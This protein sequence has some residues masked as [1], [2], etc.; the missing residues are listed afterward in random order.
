MNKHIIV[1][2][3]TPEQTARIA[4]TG[5][6]VFEVIKA[7]HEMDDDWDDL[8]EA[9]NWLSEEQLR[10]AL[11]YYAAHKA[12]LDERLASDERVEE[13]VQEVWRQ[14]PHMKPAWR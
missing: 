11:D 13:R 14:Y 3:W 8:Q 1:S 7:F 10:A 5:I 12:A 2:R 4:G 6:D 9:F